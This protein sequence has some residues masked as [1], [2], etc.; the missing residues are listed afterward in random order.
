VAAGALRPRLGPATAA[1]SLRSPLALAWR[2]HRG[3]LLGWTTGFAIMSAVFSA[4]ANSAADLFRT[5]P[6][7]QDMFR[8]LGSHAEAGD[9]Y[10]SG[11]ITLFGLLAAAHAVQATLRL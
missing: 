10:L 4:T 5:S 7:V 2:L 8:R 1:P 3:T 9:M 6:Q 11:T